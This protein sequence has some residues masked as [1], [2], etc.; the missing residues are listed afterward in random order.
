MSRSRADAIA[1]AVFVST[2]AVSGFACAEPASPSV[3]IEPKAT[4]SAVAVGG[5]LAI[6]ATIAASPELPD[7]TTVNYSA[8]ANVYDASFS[9]NHSVSGSAKVVARKIV[10]SISLPYVWKLAA[11]GENMNVSLYASAFVSPVTA[12]PSRNLSTS[13]QTVIATP[14][15]GV[16]TPISFTGSL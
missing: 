4:A 9:N 1:L 15:N 13:F 14:A 8:S 10:I 2:C 5:G 7:G 11:A 12:G 3:T 6:T 16:V